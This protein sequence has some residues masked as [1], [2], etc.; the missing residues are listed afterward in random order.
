MSYLDSTDASVLY[1][2]IADI[3]QKN[4]LTNIVD[5]GCRTGEINKYLKNYNYNYYGFDTSV[6]PIEYAKMQYPNKFFELRDWNDLISV[7]CDVVVFGSVLIY[8]KDPIT[9]FER[10]CEFYSP[11][12]AIIHEVNTKNSED[13]NYTDLDYFNRYNNTVYEFDLNIPVGHRTIID[14]K[15]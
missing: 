1:K 2:C 13:L 14:V 9:M 6:E 15:L 3:I 11:K 12:H 5:I 4:N 10:I 8:D 7:H